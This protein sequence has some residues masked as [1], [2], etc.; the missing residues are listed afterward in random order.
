VIQKPRSCGTGISP[1]DLPDELSQIQRFFATADFKRI[2]FGV[3]SNATFDPPLMPYSRRNVAGIV[4]RPR[5]ENRTLKLSLKGFIEAGSVCCFVRPSA[6]R[7][8]D[9]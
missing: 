5:V 4:T 2:P 8:R 1:V 6:I 9:D 7:K 3:T